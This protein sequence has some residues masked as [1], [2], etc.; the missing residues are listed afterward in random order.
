MD[1]NMDVYDFRTDEDMADMT[2]SEVRGTR[3]A[4]FLTG[5][6]LGGVV[7]FFFILIVGT[8]LGL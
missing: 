8:Y 2:N 6:L 3:I 5:F 1:F 7:V 4:H